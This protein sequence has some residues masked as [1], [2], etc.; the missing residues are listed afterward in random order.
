MQLLLKYNADPDVS[1]EGCRTTLRIA[2]L[3]GNGSIR[4]QHLKAIGDANPN[5]T[6]QLDVSDEMKVRYPWMRV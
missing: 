1:S 4:K 5:C 2:A 6:V 3:K